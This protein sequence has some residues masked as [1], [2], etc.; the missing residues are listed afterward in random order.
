VQPE[1]YY[2]YDP[3]DKDKRDLKVRDLLAQG[4]K[5]AAPRTRRGKQVLPLKDIVTVNTQG[6]VNLN[7]APVEVLTVLIYAANNFASIESARSA[8]ES[9]VEFRGDGKRSKTPNPD[10]AFKSIADVAKVPG[11]D[12]NALNQL[13][14]MGVQPSFHSE[15]FAVTGIGRTSRAQRTITAVVERK[16]EVFDPNSARLTSNK[17]GRSSRQR[18]ETTVR[19]MGNKKG[20]GQQ[21][22]YIRIPAIRVLQWLE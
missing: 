12:A 10:D 17:G 1:V 7:T 9:I 16:L 22:D 5:T 19:R 11:V 4:R 15:V 21:D 8:A 18:R 6:R 3:E 20:E 14:S 2:G 13:G